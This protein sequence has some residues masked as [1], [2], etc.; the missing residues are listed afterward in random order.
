MIGNKVRPRGV[1]TRCFRC[2]GSGML[3]VEFRHTS[4]PFR[5]FP[6]GPDTGIVECPCCKNGWI[7]DEVR[8]WVSGPVDFIREEPY[9]QPR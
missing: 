9:G 2:K 6:A 7:D 5:R 3:F 1:R 4:P 8:G